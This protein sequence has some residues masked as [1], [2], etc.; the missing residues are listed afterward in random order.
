MNCAGEDEEEC[1][2]LALTG[3]WKT[4]PTPM[5]AAGTSSS[6]LTSGMMEESIVPAA[7][8]SQM[9]LSNQETS[10][11]LLP[12]SV[13]VDYAAALQEAYLRGAR[14]AT[15][16][17]ASETFAG[18]N[19]GA[20]STPP[21]AVLPLSAVPN[22]LLHLSSNNANGM[23]SPR[24]PS[25]QIRREQLDET[26]PASQTTTADSNSTMIASSAVPFPFV[27]PIP[28]PKSLPSTQ[29]VISSSSGALY[30][31]TA[32]LQP[33]LPIDRKPDQAHTTQGASPRPPPYPP[34][35]M[36]MPNMGFNLEEEK[37]QKRLARN[38]A[39][40]RLRRMRKKNLVRRSR[41]NLFPRF[42][43]DFQRSSLQS[44]LTG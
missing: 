17:A 21:S 35:A 19:E 18:N 2:R 29:R 41:S 7:P 27:T 39:S 42:G 43:V 16:M 30:H 11:P 8:L 1:K 31:T 34:R 28:S 44:H 25:Q 6:I 13:V 4:P 23:S 12:N 10:D 22:P 32:H 3:Q 40:A 9:T 33:Q 36:S 37:R 26:I 38:R 20:D 15:A 24:L 5:Y 14:A